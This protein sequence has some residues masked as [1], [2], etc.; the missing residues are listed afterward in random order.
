[1][2]DRLNRSL[3]QRLISASKDTTDAASILAEALVD[4][5]RSFSQLLRAVQAVVIE[6]IQMLTPFL[7]ACYYTMLLPLFRRRLP[8]HLFTSVE[9]GI[10][11]EDA[12]GRIRRCSS[13]GHGS[14]IAS[15]QS[16]FHNLPGQT[17]VQHG[18]YL[19]HD[20]NQPGQIINAAVWDQILIPGGRIAMSMAVKSNSSTLNRTPVCPVCKTEAPVHSSGSSSLRAKCLGCNLEYFQNRIVDLQGANQE[21][22]ERLGHSLIELWI[23][24]KPH[25]YTR[26]SVKL[27]M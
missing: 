11:L 7:M 6:L 10:T 1:M 12:L 26:Q 27:R 20:A 8:Q 14:D 25:W 16:L 21:G 23:R 17:R 19:L 2:I 9:I 13:Y 18:L 4:F 24:Q 15:L 22:R 3:P 5:K